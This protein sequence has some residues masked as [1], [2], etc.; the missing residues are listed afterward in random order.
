[1]S[2]ELLKRCL[3]SMAA[4][5]VRFVW[6]LFLAAVAGGLIGCLVGTISGTFGGYS[7]LGIDYG[8]MVGS[9]IGFLFYTV[10]HWL[11]FR[12][13][14]ERVAKYLIGGTLIGSLPLALIPIYGWILS[15][16][17][18]VLGY[19]LGLVE[20]LIRRSREKRAERENDRDK[21]Q[22]VDS[23]PAL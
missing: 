16:L 19:W 11:V 22:A 8:L 9:V 7:G 6:L 4:E 21:S 17:G 12:I 20:L 5:L 1:M 3:R 10:A 2:I 13:P 18:G 14:I 15:L 23:T